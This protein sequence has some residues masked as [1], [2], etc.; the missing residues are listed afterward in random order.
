MYNKFRTRRYLSMLTIVFAICLSVGAAYAA[1]SGTLQFNG[2]VTLGH[3]GS[4]SFNTDIS[5][6]IVPI[7][8]NP[9]YEYDTRSYGTMTVSPDGQSATFTALIAEPGHTLGFTFEVHNTGTHDTFIDRIIFSSN[10]ALILAGDFMNLEGEI[11][12][13]GGSSFPHAIIIG[14]DAYTPDLDGNV[15]FTIGMD[16]SLAARR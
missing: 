1:I 3:A 15:S 9:I 12:P 13:V 4:V 11:I 7:V 6:Q 16:Y 2:D 8:S 10:G 14:W 5:L